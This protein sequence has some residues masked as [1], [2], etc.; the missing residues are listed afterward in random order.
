MMV[1][2]GLNVGRLRSCQVERAAEAT[3]LSRAWGVHFRLK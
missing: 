3:D 1:S 2:L